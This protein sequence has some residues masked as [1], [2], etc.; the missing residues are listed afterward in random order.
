MLADEVE[1]HDAAIAASGGRLASDR[2]EQLVI[3]ERA[4]LRRRFGPAAPFAFALFGCCLLL[5]VDDVGIVDAASD[6]LVRGLG[7]HH[8]GDRGNRCGRVA[9]RYSLNHA[10]LEVAS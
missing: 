10:A 5:R 2:A 6:P 1:P 8:S 4:S 3:L 7:S 9:K